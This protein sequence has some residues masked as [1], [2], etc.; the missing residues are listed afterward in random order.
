MRRRVIPGFRLPVSEL[1]HLLYFCDPLIQEIRWGIVENGKIT[2][3]GLAN[4]NSL[5]KSFLCRKDDRK[6]KL[7]SCQLFLG[8]FLG[9][10]R[11]AQGSS[12]SLFCERILSRLMIEVGENRPF[13]RD[14]PWPHKPCNLDDPLLNRDSF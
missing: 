1:P 13:V 10:T 7:E 5:S 11:E 3:R 4:L 12:R 9:F 14:A 8:V 2:D 6:L